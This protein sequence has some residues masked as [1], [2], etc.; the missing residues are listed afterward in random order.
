MPGAGL[1]GYDKLHTVQ[2]FLFFCLA[3]NPKGSRKREK[4]ENHLQYLNSNILVFSHTGSLQSLAR[5]NITQM[6]KKPF[7]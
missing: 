1:V 4:F 6:I 7:R 2:I 5:N 3:P